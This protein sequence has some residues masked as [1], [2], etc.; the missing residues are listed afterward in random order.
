ME[1]TNATMT[2]SITELTQGQFFY[3]SSH[4][5]RLHISGGDR[6]RFLHNQT[7]NNIQA[8]KPGQGCETVFLTSTARTLDLATAWIHEDHIDLL[9]SPQ[10]R[11]LLLNWLD[12]YIFFG[13]A[14]Q[15]A[16]VTD[17]TTTVRLLG[18]GWG[19]LGHWGSTPENHDHQSLEIAGMSVQVARGTGLALTG[20]TLTHASTTQIATTGDRLSLIQW[21]GEQGGQALGDEDWERVRILQGRPM[22][23]AELTE[24]YNPLETRLWQAISF[25]K[26]CYIGQETIARLNTYQGVKQELW[27]LELPTPLPP[28]TPLTLEGTTVGRITSCIPLTETA[29][30]LGYVR[31]KAGGLGLILEATTPEG[32]NLRVKVV[33]VPFLEQGVMPG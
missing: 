6:L 9:V 33:D 8:L 21:L 26:G 13:D 24:E 17:Q 12:K 5:G 31:K 23:D 28:G 11:E 27:G 30:G 3:D 25:D 15:V 16:D 22:P 32:V 10:R 29:F 4:W 1:Y 14:V 18:N 20:Y 19:E 2:P 7:S